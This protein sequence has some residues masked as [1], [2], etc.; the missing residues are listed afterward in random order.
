[1]RRAAFIYIF[2]V[3]CFDFIVLCWAP[4]L[5]LHLICCCFTSWSLWNSTVHFSFV[6]G[7]VINNHLSITVK[8]VLTS[9]N[10]YWEPGDLTTPFHSQSGTLTRANGTVQIRINMTS[11]RTGH[12]QHGLA[13]LSYSVSSPL[14]P[15]NHQCFNSTV[16]GTGC[17]PSSSSPKEDG[18]LISMSIQRIF[19]SSWPDSRVRVAPH[20]ALLPHLH[21]RP[22]HGQPGVPQSLPPPRSFWHWWGWLW[23]Q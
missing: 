11:T 5:L 16:W 12:C 14:L 19:P 23:Q 10:S 4:D 2:V 20:R 3:H 9:E 7:R 18:G 1:M 6:R 17:K 13:H 21:C 8:V 15:P 22:W